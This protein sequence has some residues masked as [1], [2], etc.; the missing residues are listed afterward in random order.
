MRPNVQRL[1]VVR[2]GYG[3]QVVGYG[4]LNLSQQLLL[5]VGHSH[6]L[7]RMRAA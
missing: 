5:L 6:M 4:N 3:A 2:D 1:L 7:T